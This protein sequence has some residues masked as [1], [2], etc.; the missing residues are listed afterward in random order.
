[1]YSGARRVSKLFAQVS[2]RHAIPPREVHKT[3]E[4]SRVCNPAQPEHWDP[5]GDQYGSQ[6]TTLKEAKW[7]T[8]HSLFGLTHLSQPS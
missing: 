1:M 5:N 4:N 3:G 2:Q 7:D 8:S 6:H